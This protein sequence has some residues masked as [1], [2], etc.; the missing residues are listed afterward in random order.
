[1]G[2]VLLDWNFEQLEGSGKIFR[3]NFLKVFQVG[4]LITTAVETNYPQ[5]RTAH[6]KYMTETDYLFIYVFSYKYRRAASRT[7]ARMQN[8]I[9]F[10]WINAF[11]K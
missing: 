4:L 1:M 6:P 2:K 9:H 7:S 11:V 3:N 5:K 10:C 8:Q